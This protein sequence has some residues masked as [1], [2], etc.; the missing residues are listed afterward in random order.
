MVEKLVVIVDVDLGNTGLGGEVEQ[1][2]TNGKIRADIKT[3]KRG[4][5][6]VRAGIGTGSRGVGL[7]GGI[8]TYAIRERIIERIPVQGF[9]KSKDRVRD[10]RLTDREYRALG[11]ILAGAAFDP[12]FST[13]T[14]MVRTLALTG[15]RRGEIINLRMG[16]I[17]VERSCIRLEEFQGRSIYPGHRLARGRVAPNHYCPTMRLIS[18]SPVPRKASH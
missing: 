9:R 4:R 10:R 16:E 6:I 7:L 8:F 15:Y 2:G 18:C 3:K 1:I 5:A 17:D 12:Q 11:K 13:V 14:K